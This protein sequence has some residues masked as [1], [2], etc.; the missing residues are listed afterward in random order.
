MNPEPK[1]RP[2]THVADF[3]D[4]LSPPD[5]SEPPVIVGGYAVNLWA[6]Y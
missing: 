4:I 1:P 6:M 3:A 5:G 2:E